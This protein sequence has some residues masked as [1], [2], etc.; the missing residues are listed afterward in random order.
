[1]SKIRSSWLL[2]HNDSANKKDSILRQIKTVQLNAAKV[3]VVLKERKNSLKGIPCS[4]VYAIYLQI[5]NWS[6]AS[7]S[8]KDIKEP[9]SSY[10]HLIISKFLN[11]KW[12]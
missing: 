6:I 3:A 2:S 11:A 8:T 5:L 10:D 12:E 4:I 9:L 7:E 1:M